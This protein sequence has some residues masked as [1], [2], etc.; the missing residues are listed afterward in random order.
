MVFFVVWALGFLY[1]FVEERNLV[2]RQQFGM[3]F[4]EAQCLGNIF[5]HL[6]SV[7]RQHHG[8]A[9][10][11]LVQLVD[12]LLG[13][14][15]HAV[16]DDNVAGIDAVDG[17]V[18]DGAHQ[19]AGMFCD[20]ES[21]HHLVV[22]HAYLATIDL[23]L[24]AMSGNFLDLFQTASVVVGFRIGIAQSLSDGVGGVVFDV[25]GKMQQMFFVVFVGMHGS[26]G[27]YSFG[28]GAGLVEYDS[29]DLCQL[30]D[31]VGAFD[32]DTIA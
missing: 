4:V 12:G 32:E 5:G 21:L 25:C 1:E 18:D 2:G 13:I 16:V 14:G 11:R 17:D 7:A 9:D 23:G 31:V 19:F 20:A 24:D 6:L 8:L 15:F 27:E 26:D 3:H 30:V 10:T 29:I 28:E 22:A